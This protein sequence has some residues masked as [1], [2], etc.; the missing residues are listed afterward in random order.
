[1]HFLFVKKLLDVGASQAGE[2]VPVDV[3]HVVAGGVVSVIREVS[4]ASAFSGKV[5]AATAVGQSAQR[6]QPHALDAIQSTVGKQ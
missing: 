5:L 4:A 3:S 6:I 2:D 1:M